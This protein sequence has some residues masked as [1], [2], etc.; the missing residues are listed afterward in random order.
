MQHRLFHF[1]LSN[2]SWGLVCL[3][4]KWI[5]KRFRP[6]AVFYCQKVISNHFINN[7]IS[8]LQSVDQLTHQCVG[9]LAQSLEFAPQVLVFDFLSL[10]YLGH[11][12]VD[13]M[14]MSW[15]KYHRD[16]RHHEKNRKK[17][18]R[19]VGTGRVSLI[20]HKW[21]R[22]TIL[23]NNDNNINIFFFLKEALKMIFANIAFLVY[24]QTK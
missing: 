21:I 3:D 8:T 17:G 7:I 11:A 15:D 12:R 13:C 23:A 24:I 18:C 9:S 16:T 22:T 4:E 2:L 14:S 20:G 10:I 19:S 5:S 6:L 1:M